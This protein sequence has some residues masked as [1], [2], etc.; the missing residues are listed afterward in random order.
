M[1]RPAKIVVVNSHPI[2]YFTALYKHISRHPDIDLHVIYLSDMGLNDA[3]DIG[4]NQ[5]IA[6]D[7]DLLDGYS[8]EF[9]GKRYADGFS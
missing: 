5:N 3:V 9:C 7:F 8:Y 6:A 4:F 1:N 2:T